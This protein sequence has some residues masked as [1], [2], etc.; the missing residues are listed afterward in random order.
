[1]SLWHFMCLLSSRC[2]VNDLEQILQ[3][4]LLGASS[5]LEALLSSSSSTQLSA[6]EA[7]E[8]MLLLP[9]RLPAGR[10]WLASGFLMP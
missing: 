7:G 3:L 5:E 10:S 1:M 4:N 9:P 2:R 6:G 8:A